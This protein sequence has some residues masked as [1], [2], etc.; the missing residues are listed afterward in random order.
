MRRHAITI[1][2]LS[3]TLALGACLSPAAQS[4]RAQLTPQQ[5]G[6]EGRWGSVGGPVAYTATFQN[7]AFTSTEDGT[8]APLA[9]GSYR[10][11]GQ[12]QVAITSRSRTSGQESSIN[13]SQMASDRLACVN[14]GGTRFELTRRV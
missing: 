9:T 1:A 8:G 5:T 6:V 12:S 13:C 3:A 2:I 10:N 7:G 14:S 4:P 11:L